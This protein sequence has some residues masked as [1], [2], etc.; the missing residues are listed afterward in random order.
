MI[1]FGLSSLETQ[2]QEQKA[3]IELQ[4]RYKICIAFF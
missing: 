1:P 4:L 2:H 3:N